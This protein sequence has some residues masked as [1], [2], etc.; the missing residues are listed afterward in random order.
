[1][2]CCLSVF[3]VYKI[4]EIDKDLNV[5]YDNYSKQLENVIKINMRKVV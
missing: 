2:I 1:M 4:S 3:T 5:L